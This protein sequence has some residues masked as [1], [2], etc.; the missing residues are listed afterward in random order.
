MPEHVYKPEETVPHSGLYLVMHRG[1]RRNHEATLFA[2]ECF[3]ACLHCGMNVRFQLIRAAVP[4]MKD[5]DFCQPK[6]RAH[7]RGRH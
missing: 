2:G 1:H 3:P 7:T 5:A 4:I 6:V